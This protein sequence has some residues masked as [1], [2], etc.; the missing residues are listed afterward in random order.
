MVEEMKNIREEFDRRGVFWWDESADKI[1]RTIV[2]VNKVRWSIINGLGTYGGYR[3]GEPNKGLLEIYDGETETGFLT[4]GDAIQI[5]FKE[6][7]NDQQ[8]V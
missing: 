8:I 7:L 5:I 3:F 2:E 6:G 1:D 4:S